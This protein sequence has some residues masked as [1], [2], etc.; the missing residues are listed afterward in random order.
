MNERDY[1]C[2]NK[3]LAGDGGFE[4]DG[5]IRYS[6]KNPGDDDDKKLFNLV[7]RKVRAGI[8]TA[9][10]RVCRWFPILGNNKREWNYGDDV[11]QLS[12]H[13][14]SKLHNWMMNTENLSYVALSSAEI[15]FRP[16]Y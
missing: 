12:I 1:F 10:P 4:G 9:F 5:P 14:S 2:L 16:Y 6:Y 3:W 7:F 13:A 11:M 8:E 15:I